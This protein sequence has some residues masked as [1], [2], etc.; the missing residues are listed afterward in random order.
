[1]RGVLDRFNISTFHISGDR[2]ILDALNGT[3]IKGYQIFN[4][5]NLAKRLNTMYD[6]EIAYK[7]RLFQNYTPFNGGHTNGDSR[8]LSPNTVRDD[9]SY[10]AQ[11]DYYNNYASMPSGMPESKADTSTPKP[12]MQRNHVDLY[13]RN[14]NLFPDELD[15]LN[16]ED[17]TWNKLDNPRGLL[18]KTK[19]LFRQ[20]KINT[21]ISSFHTNNPT[22]EPKGSAKSIYGLS[23]GRNLLKKQA[24]DN[25]GVFLAANNSGYDNPY[26]RVWTHHYQ[27]DRLDKLIRPFVDGRDTGNPVGRELIDLHTWTSL[28]TPEG[29][30]K[31]GN[32]KGDRFKGW[33]HKNERWNNSV[34]NKNGFVNITP[35][36]RDG[37]MSSLH[38][39]QC[40]FSIENL[41][42]KG[43]SPFEFERNLSWEQRGPMGGRIMWFP[44]YG[45]SFSETTSAQWNS[46]TFIGRGEDVFTYINTKRTGTLSFMMVV[47][48][49]SVTD[50]AT[51]YRGGQQDYDS[52]KDSDI[53][54]YFAGCDSGN[55]ETG[56]SSPNEM[57]STPGGNTVNGWEGG[58]GD[59]NTW[60]SFNSF[61]A[62]T[63]Y[64][65]HE[66]PRPEEIQP[67]PVPEPTPDSP[68]VIDEPPVEPTPAQ[69]KELV[70]YV[71]YPNNYSGKYDLPTNKSS[72]VEFAAYLI[73]GIGTNKKISGFAPGTKPTK[74]QIITQTKDIPIDSTTYSNLESDRG[75][76]IY[77][78]DN[79]IGSRTNNRYKNGEYS[80][81]YP[82]KVAFWAKGGLTGTYNPD[83]T[84]EWKEYHYRP[85]GLYKTPKNSK[86]P[87][88]WENTYDDQL[89]NGH[90]EDKTSF[91]L[92]SSIGYDKVAQ[93]FKHEDHKDVN[94][95][96]IL[97]S[98]TEI[99]AALYYDKYYNNFK[100]AGIVNEER[101]KS[102]KEI[103]ET[104]KILEVQGF[105]GVSSHSL[106]TV[107]EKNQD[108][109]ARTRYESV[110]DWLKSIP[111][112]PFTNSD[113]I[114]NPAKKL[115]IPDGEKVGDVS[116]INHKLDRY[117]KVV[118]KVQMD[119]TKKISET[120]QKVEDKVEDVSETTGKYEADNDTPFLPF[121]DAVSEVQSGTK[122]ILSENQVFENSAIKTTSTT[123]L[124]KRDF[125]KN[126]GATW[127]SNW[128]AESLDID[129]VHSFGYKLMTSEMVEGSDGN[130]IPKVVFKEDA[131]L[132]LYTL[133]DKPNTYFKFFND[134]KKLTL[135]SGSV[136][137]PKDK[138]NNPVSG[139]DDNIEIESTGITQEFAQNVK[140]KYDLFDVREDDRWQTSKP[141]TEDGLNWIRYD[142]EYQFFKE[143]KL[144]NPIV[145]DNLI[146]KLQYFD[147]AFH[148]MTPEGFNGRLNFLHQCT[149]QGNTVSDSDQAGQATN[150]AFGRP[151]VCVLRLGDFYNQMII[152]DSININYDSDSG[153]Q[154]DLNPEGNGVQPLLAKVSLNFN[155]IGGGDMYGPIRRLQNAMT[156]NYYANTG[157][158]DNR[159][160]YEIRHWDHVKADAYTNGDEIVDEWH[161]T[162]I[163]DSRIMENRKDGSTQ[164][165]PGDNKVSDGRKL[166]K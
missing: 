147:P 161:Y 60:T 114:W 83:L 26:C 53:L 103:F 80:V 23:H 159:A 34:L 90:Y 165:A 45:I 82:T 58:G 144:K 156:F 153:V 38:T 89:V 122:L 105:G 93:H 87:L 138:A 120:E 154:W 56:F 119:E 84:K 92:N 18:T 128:G 10:T 148:S 57:N 129:K 43:M 150:L 31:E 61:T 109:L 101:V 143:L 137:K 127:P 133:K 44:P 3:D 33:K 9:L 149:R 13:D 99:A 42:W 117:A 48:H 139:D 14:I 118:I 5:I 110:R 95:N 40:M 59:R 142:Q 22:V 66:G 17:A 132:I 131:I 140:E 97:Y 157:L 7:S 134:T 164:N 24:E 6:N 50:Y 162:S 145:F 166:P 126:T 130:K 125:T 41:A 29:S 52:L 1:M 68:P 107:A 81:I 116:S 28:F 15:A 98:F 113:I 74:N 35:K 76:E 11:Y 19:E 30:D 8:F 2:H 12:G 106:T 49:P 69:P 123:Y 16:G 135:A 75:Y 78:R 151:P 115:L 136:V 155:F 62:P 36:Y 160:D 64:S 70:F 88:Y 27:Y 79:G 63:P 47:D 141:K 158:Y 21:I 55:A 32:F 46:H 146:Q 108:V 124:L 94:G 65:V 163:N 72:Q 71:F 104:H 73:N 25:P 111:N 4:S 51:W 96:T 121:D 20:N 152:I 100:N 37:G 39:K 85:N 67:K 91:G 102:L 86:D 77:N 54:R 112:T